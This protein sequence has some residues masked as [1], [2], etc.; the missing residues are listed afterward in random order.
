MGVALTEGWSLGTCVGAGGLPPHSLLYERVGCS[1]MG[2]VH[3]EKSINFS[4]PLLCNR[5]PGYP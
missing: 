3:L 1:F 4:R 2:G 5:I